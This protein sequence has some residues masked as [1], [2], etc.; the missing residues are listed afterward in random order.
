M[1]NRKVIAE[2]VGTMILVIIG[3]GTAM[4]TGANVVATA[5]AF[6]F[7]LLVLVYAIGPVSGCH[8]NPAVSLAMYLR[9]RMPASDLLPY[10]VAQLLGAVAGAFILKIFYWTVN[11]TAQQALDASGGNLL[12]SN[13]TA[14]IG[15]LAAFLVEIVVSAI[16]VLSILLVT[17]KVANVAFAGIAIG[18]ALLMVHL[19]AIGLTGTSVNPA[20]SIGPA[21]LSGD[22]DA[23]KDLWCFILAPLIGGALAAFAHPFIAAAAEPRTEPQPFN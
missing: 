10:V 13:S 20:R 18:L 2:F 12:G 15:G 16:F 23:I 17:D 21:L 4:A 11:D 5:M 8:V 19:V 7:V 14:I 3:C 1:L 9:G 6:G 22:S